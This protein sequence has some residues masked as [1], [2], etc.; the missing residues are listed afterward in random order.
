MRASAVK[1]RLTS[2]GHQY[3]MTCA[4]STIS[5]YGQLS[6]MFGGVSQVR[7]SFHS[8]CLAMISVIVVSMLSYQALSAQCVFSSF[9]DTSMVVGVLHLGFTCVGNSC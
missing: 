1:D 9:I 5:P 4:G 2:S 6:E 8:Y 3:A 7:Q